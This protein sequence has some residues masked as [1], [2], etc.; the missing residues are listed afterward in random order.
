MTRSSPQTL[1]HH[2]DNQL[3]YER[4]LVCAFRKRRTWIERGLGTLGEV[5]GIFRKAKPTVPKALVS[6]CLINLVTNICIIFKYGV[7]PSL[8][9]HRLSTEDC[10]S[11]E[12]F[13]QLGISSKNKS[14]SDRGIWN[15]VF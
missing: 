6:V 11:L 4:E 13:S 10:A 12:T 3:N 8:N 9:I 2:H 7:K 15:L 5:T 14:D 1:L